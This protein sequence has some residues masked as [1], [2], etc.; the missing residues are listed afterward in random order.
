[1]I[2]NLVLRSSWILTLSPEIFKVILKKFGR[3]ELYIAFVGFLEMLRRCIW[4]FFR[5]ETEH[6]NNI[7][8]LKAV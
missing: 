6:I 8:N 5:M 4:N 2:I 1:V 3:A 7:N